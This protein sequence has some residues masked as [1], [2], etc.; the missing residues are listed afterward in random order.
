MYP[1]LESVSGKKFASQTLSSGAYL[2][3]RHGLNIERWAGRGQGRGA[4]RAQGA[5]R[6]W[7]QGQ[8]AG[9]ISQYKQ[10]NIKY[11]QSES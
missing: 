10:F 1:P 5:S 8:G 4:G 3:T 11:K 6:G 7:G 9:G 2:V